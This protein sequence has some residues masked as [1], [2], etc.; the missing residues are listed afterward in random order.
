MDTLVKN[1]LIKHLVKYKN[2]LCDYD[3]KI[4]N[5]PCVMIQDAIDNFNGCSFKK[6]LKLKEL[7]S[8]YLNGS[9]DNRELNFWIIRIW[10]GIGR[11]KESEDNQLKIK[12][13]GNDL[14]NNKNVTISTIASLSKVA[15]FV[16]PQKY[17]IY[18]SRALFS[19]NWLLFVSDSCEYFFKPSGRNKNLGKYDLASIINEETGIAIPRSISIE[20]YLNYCYLINELY[21]EVF[22]EDKNNRQPYKMEMLLFQI[23]P[24]EIVKEIEAYLGK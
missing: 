16:N 18:D 13:F 3:A 22:K 23:A 7:L 1:K 11:F 12:S 24:N 21:D 6:N 15:S 17:F 19:L 8:G 2:S 14:L 4:I 20:T 10:G 9:F 5:C